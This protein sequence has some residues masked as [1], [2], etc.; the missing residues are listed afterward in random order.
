VFAEPFLKIVRQ[1]DVKAIGIR[2]ALQDVNVGEV[3]VVSLPKC[4][5]LAEP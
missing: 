1:T 2:D 5:W 4:R 3:H